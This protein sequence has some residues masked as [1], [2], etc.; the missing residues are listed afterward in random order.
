LSSTPPPQ[1]HH[2]GRADPGYSKGMDYGEHME[3]K[4]IRGSGGGA[5][6]GSR[7]RVLGGVRGN[8]P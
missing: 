8:A 2:I 7:S 4:P 1:H 3:R 5:N 6:S